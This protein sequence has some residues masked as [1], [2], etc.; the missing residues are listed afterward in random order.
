MAEEMQEKASTIEI[1]TEDFNT[2][3]TQFQDLEKELELAQEV[4]INEKKR[5]DELS[6]Q[7]LRLQADFDNHRK[8]TVETT[9]R[10]KEDGLVETIEKVIPLLDTF[11]QA[12]SLTT[13]ETIAK[14]LKMIYK[15]FEDM[16]TSF[17]IVEIEALGQEF[18]PNFHNAVMQV[19]AKSKDDKNKVVEVY[20]KGYILDKRVVRHSVVC[21]GK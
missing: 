6:N 21:V 14:G 18:D 8:R 16:L 7:M 3:Q 20:Q 13:D 17:N 9:R 11:S 10:L 2:L 12:I 5:S 15:Q 19:E 1:S 4:A